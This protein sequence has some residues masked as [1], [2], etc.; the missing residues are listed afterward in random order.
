MRLHATHTE[1]ITAGQHPGQHQE[2]HIVHMN[3]TP[4]PTS[5]PYSMSSRRSS[6]KANMYTRYVL[7]AGFRV[8]FILHHMFDPLHF[9]LAPIP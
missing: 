2:T 9:V 7:Y 1:T 5:A 6:N 4:I 8:V 3:T